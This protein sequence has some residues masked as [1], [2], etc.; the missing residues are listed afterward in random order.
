M[1]IFAGIIAAFTFMATPAMADCNCQHR[2]HTNNVV[3]FVVGAVIGSVVTH[4]YHE[5]REYHEYH[6]YQHYYEPPRVVYVEPPQPVCWVET[7][8]DYYNRPYSVE[9]CK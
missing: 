7:R 5:Y 6:E 2:H 1:K 3:P 4:E 8:Y 9:I